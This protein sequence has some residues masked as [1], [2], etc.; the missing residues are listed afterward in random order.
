MD[1]NYKKLEDVI[2]SELGETEYLETG[3]TEKSSAVKDLTALYK[4][5]LEDEKLR[6]EE[7][8]KTERLRLEEEKLKIEENE[9][10]ERLRLEEEKLE[11]EKQANSTQIRENFK[12]RIVK[13]CIAGAEIILPLAAYI[14]LAAKGFKFEETGTF[15]SSTF[16]GLFGLFKP[17]R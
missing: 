10:I 17:K 2:R 9:K 14:W 15:T 12:D 8:E 6:I 11:V 4:L 3:G 13:I 16:K 5:K 1:E 7:K